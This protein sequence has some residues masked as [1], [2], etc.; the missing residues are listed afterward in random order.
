MIYETKRYYSRIAGSK[1]IMPDGKELYFYHG[2]HDLKEEDYIDEI[3]RI[4]PVAGQEPDI[5]NGKK[6]FEVYKAELDFLIKTGNPLLYIQGTQPEPLPKIGADKNAL[7]ETE[8]LAAQ[9]RERSMGGSV[10]GDA[11]TG[12]IGFSDPNSST[13][14]PTLRGIILKERPINVAAKNENNSNAARVAAARQAAA[15]KGTSSNS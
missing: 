7:S 2:F 14:D 13:V 15:Q 10:T 4:N 11:N 5:R 6:A 1:V 8:V 9:A 3:C 12:S